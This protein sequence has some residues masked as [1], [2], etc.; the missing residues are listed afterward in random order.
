MR[1]SKLHGNHARVVKGIEAAATRFIS[2]ITAHL[3]EVVRLHRH[4]DNG[5]TT[6]MQNMEM[7]QNYEK[8]PKMTKSLKRRGLPRIEAYKILR[9]INMKN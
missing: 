3:I 7:S 2:D 8:C 6:T 1:Y 9:I 5:E 4:T